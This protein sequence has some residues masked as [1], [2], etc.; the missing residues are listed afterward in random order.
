MV[1]QRPHRGR[2][3]ARG[4]M[5]MRTLTH[6]VEGTGDAPLR[7]ERSAF[8]ATR[9]SIVL[10]MAFTCCSSPRGLSF[11]ANERNCSHAL[12][13]FSHASMLYSAGARGAAGCEAH[14]HL[15]HAPLPHDP[16]AQQRGAEQERGPPRLQDG[17]DGPGCPRRWCVVCVCACV[18]LRARVCVCVCGWRARVWR[19]CTVRVPVCEGVGKGIR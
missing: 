5:L 11:A 18:C 1:S 17:Q 10:P 7:A 8:E 14:G 4:C 3:C 19:V 16:S 15:G 6:S 12:M 13:C 9:P 2:A